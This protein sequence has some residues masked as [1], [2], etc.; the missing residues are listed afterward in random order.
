MP[1]EPGCQGFVDKGGPR[2]GGDDLVQ[3]GQAFQSV[4]QSLFVDIGLKRYDPI[5]NRLVG[6][7]GMGEWVHGSKLL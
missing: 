1:F 3:V 4:G 6:R 7:K 2:D 5:A